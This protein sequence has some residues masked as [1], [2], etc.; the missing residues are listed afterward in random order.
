[1]SLASFGYQTFVGQVDSHKQGFL[2]FI[3]RHLGATLISYLLTDFLDIFTRPAF[4]TH[5]SVDPFGASAM[6]AVHHTYKGSSLHDTHS[7]TDITDNSFFFSSPELLLA[8]L[9]L[10]LKELDYQIVITTGS[11]IS[12]T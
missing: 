4:E 7:A 11:A 8:S 3:L 10:L 9:P 12:T 2:N 5:L 6:D 1:L